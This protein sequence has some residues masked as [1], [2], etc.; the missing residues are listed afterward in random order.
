MAADPKMYDDMA[1]EEE[2]ESA[3]EEDAEK[4]AG[5]EDLD[6]TFKMHAE[7]AGMDTPE[8]MEAFK[9]AIERCVDLRDEKAYGPSEEPTADEDTDEA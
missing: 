9:M 7:A 6:E 3:D 2:G 4:A 8:K 5:A 1:L